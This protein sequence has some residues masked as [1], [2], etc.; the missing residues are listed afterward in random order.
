M[1]QACLCKR[2]FNL[3]HRKNLYLRTAKVERSF[4]NKKTWNTSF[5]N[6]FIK[7][8]EEVSNK[9]FE[10]KM[11]HR[12]ISEDIMNTRKRSY[13]LVYFDPPYKRK[14]EKHPKDYYSLYHFYEGLLDYDNWS[15]RIDWGTKNRRLK[16]EVNGWHKGSIE[17]NFDEL[18]RKFQN[19]TIAV[20]YGSSGYPSIYKI[21]KLMKKYKPVVRVMKRQYIYKL[22]QKNGG[23]YEVLIIGS[24]KKPGSRLVVRPG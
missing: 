23:L 3:F 16:R 22:N 4:G 7:F 1:F 8:N 19:S 6:L 15:R 9:I 11:K 24:Q 2:P 5:K 14:N 20:S 10:T 21:T 12:S 18:F 13:D 17:D